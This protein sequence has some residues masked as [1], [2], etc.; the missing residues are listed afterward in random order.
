MELSLDL[1]RRYTYADYLTWID[2]RRRELVDG[3]IRMMSPAA[4]TQHQQISINLAIELGGYLRKRKGTCRVFCAPFDV[5]LPEGGQTAD[6][7]V[8]T[9]VQPDICV[10]CDPAKIDD[11]GCVGAPDMVVEILSPSTTRHDLHTKFKLYE[12][13]GVREYWVAH[14]VEGVDVYLLQPD[15]KYG[16][17]AWYPADQSAPVHVLPG[18][19]IDLK[20]VYE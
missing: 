12:Q 10:I 17:S 20:A 4:S 14:Q 13:A 18:C 3:F 1:N 2:D 5:R 8:Y 16:E 9:V 6:D 15:G 7:Q 11:R 19:E